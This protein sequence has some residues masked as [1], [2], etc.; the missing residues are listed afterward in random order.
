MRLTRLIPACAGK[1]H[2][3]QA[4]QP[5][6][7]AHP[8]VC[9][10]NGLVHAPRSDLPGSSPRV[11][12]KPASARSWVDK[13]GL[14]PACA[15]KT[16][17]P[18]FSEIEDWAHPRVCGENKTYTGSLRGKRGSSPRVRGKHSCPS[19]GPRAKRLIPACAGKTL[20]RVAGLDSRP[21]HPRVCG[22]NI[23]ARSPNTMFAGSSPRVR[24]KQRD[25]WTQNALTGLIPACAGKTGRLG[26][27]SRSTRAHPRVCGE[28][29][30]LGQVHDLHRGSSPRV[31]GKH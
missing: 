23:R 7:R 18:D 27:P 28:N 22:E 16:S 10:E 12:G 3:P 19:R 20:L 26:K 2:V 5:R 17:T 31:R 21:A 30:A 14:I 6:A 4:K 9:G 24:G 13:N 15:G 11:R 8:R 25:F 1:T 29:L